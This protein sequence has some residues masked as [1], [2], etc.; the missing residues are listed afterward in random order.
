MRFDIRYRTCFTYD[1]T[2][3][4][5]H[6]E[7]RACPATTEHQKLLSYRVTVAPTARVHSFTDYW[8]TRVD[9]FGVRAP[10]DEL[11]VLAEAAV[12]TTPLPAVTAAPQVSQ[13]AEAA[14]VRS[15]VE[16]LEPTPLTEWNDELRRR[17]EALVAASGEDLIGAVLAIH[18]LVRTSIRYEAGATG[19]DTPAVEVWRS[20][21]GVCQDHAHLAVALCRSVGI[22]A[23]YVS[24][25]LFSE[26]AGGLVSAGAGGADRSSS[27]EVQTHAWFEAILP[28]GIELALDPTNGRQVSDHH[29]RIG[30]GRDYGDVTPLHGVHL[31]EATAALEATVT[32]QRFPSHVRRDLDTTSP[33]AVTTRTPL[34]SATL[35]RADDH[36][37]LQQQQQQQQQQR[38]TQPERC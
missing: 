30:H 36:R 32:M 23:R 11:E 15:E 5:S 16:Y 26:H 14:F 13:L 8:G 35:E 37:R 38:A 20:G 22:P 18:R 2:V 4:E 28:G 29:V 34:A 33:A 31:G 7:L 27:V 21:V 3:A 10:H 17:A 12:E 25:Y 24:G 9:T 1:R 6:N 19:V